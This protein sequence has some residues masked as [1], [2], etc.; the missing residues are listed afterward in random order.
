MPTAHIEGLSA[1]RGSVVSLFFVCLFPSV[2]VVVFV[3]SP[4]VSLATIARQAL[5]DACIFVVWQ[6]SLRCHCR[7][8]DL[9]E[10]LQE[11]QDNGGSIEGFLMQFQVD[12]VQNG[13]FHASS[14][15]PAGDGQ[16]GF[17][18]QE[19]YGLEAQAQ[20]HNGVVA[21]PV[22]SPRAMVVG[23]QVVGTVKAYYEE[24]AYGFVNVQGC[25]GDIYFQ[26][27]DISVEVCSWSWII[28]EAAPHANDQYM[29]MV[30]P[31][32]LFAS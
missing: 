20:C 15:K 32:D 2:S 29:A 23:A 21:T 16:H 5:V 12:L 10:D 31:C 3:G 6:E 19:M 17:V 30:G 9:R 7:R 13:V 18:Q 11:L 1:I 14:V 8:K 4:H 22:S 28:T 26:K 24:R 25:T 27:A